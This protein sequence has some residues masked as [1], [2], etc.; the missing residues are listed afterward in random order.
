VGGVLKA[1]VLEQEPGAQALFLSDSFPGLK[2]GGFL[3]YPAAR[4]RCALVFGEI[5]GMAKL[6]TEPGL[7]LPVLTPGASLRVTDLS[8]FV[9]IRGGA[10]EGRLP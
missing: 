5:Y 2:P 10:G 4:D 6:C 8:C 7:R 9:E 3:R 1:L